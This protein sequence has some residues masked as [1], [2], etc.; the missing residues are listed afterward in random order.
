MALRFAIG[1]VGAVVL[2]SALL[3]CSEVWG[4]DDLSAASRAAPD[5]GEPVAPTRPPLTLSVRDQDPTKGAIR[6]AVTIGKATDESGIRSY[7]LYWGSNTGEKLAKAGEVPATGKDVTYTVE[8]PAPEGA[9]Q[10][11]A[12]SANAA[13]ESSEKAWARLDDNFSKLVEFSA[14][15]REQLGSGARPLID[16]INGKLLLVTTRGTNSEKIGLFRCS[17]DGTG[18]AYTDIGAQPSA[19]LRRAA[20]AVIDPVSKKLLIFTLNSTD[21]KLGFYRCNLDGTE[22]SHVP[23]EAGPDAKSGFAPIPLVDTAAARLLVIVRNDANGYKHGL[24]RCRLD[25]LGCV[26]ADISA[27]QPDRSCLQ[28]SPVIDALGKRLIVAGRNAANDNKLSVFQCNVE[29]AECAHKDASSGQGGESGHFPSAAIDEAN[30]KLLVVTRNGASAGRP[31]LFRCDLDGAGACVHADIS[32]GQ[33]AES[34][35]RS[36]LVVDAVHKKVL[37]VTTNNANFG[38]LSLFRCNLDGSDCTHTDISAGQGD[39][40]GL[41]PLPVLDAANSRLLVVTQNAGGPS[42]FSIGLW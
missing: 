18:C 34:G 22:C 6:A 31:G 12:F 16:T 32:A 39:Y 24:F 29:G 10:L 26:Y 42:L 4:F 15:Q 23:I 40:S 19:E 1:F 37:V 14:D 28:F 30:R 3:A 13:G 9:S 8:A 11:L 33:G 5:G 35:N 20:S 41:G 38:K 7:A 17:L 25:G 36:S 27:G 21:T 2:A